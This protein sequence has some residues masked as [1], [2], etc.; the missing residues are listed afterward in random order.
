MS[1]ICGDCG[2]EHADFLQES[3]TCPG[4]SIQSNSTEES[5]AIYVANGKSGHSVTLNTDDILEGTNK[6]HTPTRA[7]AALSANSPIDLDSDTGVISH[8]ESGVTANTYGDA[9]KYPV[10]TVDDKGHITSVTEQNLPNNS[11]GD[12]LIA[13]EALT[14]TGILVRTAANTWLFR[15]V[16]GTAGRITVTN[17]D[18]VA[19]NPVIDLVSV[20]STPGT[21]GTNAKVAKVTVDAYGRVTAVE[22]VDIDF[23]ELEF[24]A[25]LGDLTNVD[26]TVD[27]PG[28]HPHL[29]WNGTKWLSS[30]NVGIGVAP[31]PVGTND[32]THSN[33]KLNVGKAG[34]FTVSPIEVAGATTLAMYTQGSE[35]VTT[36]YAG[37]IG[38]LAWAIDDDQTIRPGTVLAGS[39]A[40]LQ[41]VT[42]YRT[43][44]GSLSA[45][46][47]SI[48]LSG[49]GTTDV[50]I[51]Q[52]ITTPSIDAVAGFTGLVDLIIGHRID[53]QKVTGKT[54]TAQGQVQSGADDTNFFAGKTQFGGTDAPLSDPPTNPVDIYSSNPRIRTSRTPASAAAAGNQGE[55]C[56][57]A[58]YI[59][60]CTA[61]NTWK[62]V[63]IAT[64]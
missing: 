55:I 20:N 11:I 50:L 34:I 44:G 61:A 46:A 26:P 6:Y 48:S 58:N 31:E 5:G 30:T 43:S 7:R 45:H 17:T 18:G 60:V 62:R 23:P 28:T 37:H 57:D 22:E 1:T 51:G 33:T 56:W 25:S 29:Y 3:E 53:A 42:D 49:I 47:A 14:G 35:T 15:T 39:I 63:A 52:R 54:T 2:H 64:W 24:T 27:S 59:Y 12:D 16:T 32:A 10:I 9:A 38:I 41:F 8:N 40:Y 21:Y 36:Q 4:S 19:G 13:I